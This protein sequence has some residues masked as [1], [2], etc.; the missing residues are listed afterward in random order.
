MSGCGALPQGCEERE[1]LWVPALNEL[2]QRLQLPSPPDVWQGLRG[3]S[4][5]VRTQDCVVWTAVTGC[6]LILK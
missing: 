3:G 6:R 4:G 2:E 5:T 1:G